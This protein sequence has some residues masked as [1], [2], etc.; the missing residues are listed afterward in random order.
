THDDDGTRKL[1]ITSRYSTDKIVFHG[2]EADRATKTLLPCN[3]TLPVHILG[4]LVEI[5][6]M[7]ARY[8][9]PDDTR[10]PMRGG[11]LLRGARLSPIVKDEV[12]EEKGG[13]LVHV[14]DLKGFP[15]VYG[16]KPELP[17]AAYFLRNS[18]PFESVARSRDWYL[19]ARTPELVRNLG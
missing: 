3:I 18:L 9:P 19:F 16:D 17:G 14:K 12:L 11:W 4:T 2:Q 1:K 7:Q 13:V 15:P 5:E 6:A 8:I 10:S